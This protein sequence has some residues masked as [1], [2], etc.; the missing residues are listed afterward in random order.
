MLA[1]L[2]KSYFNVLIII[3]REYFLESFSILSEPGTWT[4][5][6]KMQERSFYRRTHTP[7]NTCTLTL[8]KVCQKHAG[9]RTVCCFWLA[10]ID[11]FFF[12]ISSKQV[13]WVCAVSSFSSYWVWH[14][15]TFSIQHSQAYHTKIQRASRAFCQNSSSVCL[16]WRQHNPFTGTIQISTGLTHSSVPE[17]RTSTLCL[18]TCTQ[19]KDVSLTCDQ[20][21]KAI[22]I[23]WR[24]KGFLFVRICS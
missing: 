10:M 15:F 18:T 13:E 19:L 1:W 11:P 7:T 21:L 12:F 24:Q 9:T 8:F 5:K 16:P 14:C 22:V 17:T 6:M 4:R 20:M 23:H 3:R 2:S